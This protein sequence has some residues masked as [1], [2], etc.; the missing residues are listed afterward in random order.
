MGKVKYSI[1]QIEPGRPCA[2]WAIKKWC[3]G[4]QGNPG[5]YLDL[6][7]VFRS[8]DDAKEYVR[9]MMAEMMAA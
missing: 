9:Q 8:R 1:E 4:E 7:L 5:F 6:G 3:P 2:Q